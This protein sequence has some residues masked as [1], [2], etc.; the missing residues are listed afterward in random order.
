[1]CTEMD[2][3]L[4]SEAV[5]TSQQTSRKEGV[6]ERMLTLIYSLSE[7]ISYLTKP[8]EKESLTD[9]FHWQ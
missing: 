1:M 7:D 4:W 9:V 5:L 2:Q 8:P 6:F 3:V